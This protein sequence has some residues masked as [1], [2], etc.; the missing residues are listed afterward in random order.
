AYDIWRERLLLPEKLRAAVMAVTCTDCNRQHLISAYGGDPGKVRVV[1]HGLDVDRFRPAPR[2]TRTEPIILSVGRL[3]EQKGFDCLIR[4]CADLAAEGHQFQCRIIGD[5]PMRPQ[6]EALG[7][8]LG[9]NGRVQFL[10]KM[11]Q[12]ELMKH[13]ATADLFALLCKPA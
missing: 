11:H 7:A 3:V 10:G 4:A 6:L 12:E 9:L 13:Y 5:G 2:S 8:E 1:Y